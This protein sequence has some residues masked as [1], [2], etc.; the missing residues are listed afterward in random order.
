MSASAVQ[1]ICQLVVL[2]GALT[3]AFSNFHTARANPQSRGNSNSRYRNFCKWTI[4]NNIWISF[5]SAIAIAVGGIGNM[6]AGGITS[7]ESSERLWQ[8]I[9]AQR[10]DNKELM[11]ELQNVRSDY[12]HLQQKLQPIEKF[13]ESTGTGIQQAVDR[14]SLGISAESTSERKRQSVVQAADFKRALD[15]FDDHFEAKSFDSAVTSL[16][17]TVGLSSGLYIQGMIRFA[18]DSRRRRDNIIDSFAVRLQQLDFNINEL[19]YE[20]RL[21]IRMGQAL[22]GRAQSL[23]VDGDGMEAVLSCDTL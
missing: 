21:P 1:L 12:K 9:R 7:K 13:V 11:F 16:V 2:L 6:V 8:E 4:R 19:E 18:K 20:R 3:V 17:N 22:K 23:G 10:A 14:M 5:I 15:I